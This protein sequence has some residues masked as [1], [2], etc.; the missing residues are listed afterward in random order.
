MRGLRTLHTRVRSHEENALAIARLLDRHDAVTRVHYPGLVTHPDHPLARAQ[1][2]GFGGI[3]S[4]QL[5]GGEQAIHAF[6]NGLKCFTLAESLGG[7]E[8][9]VCHP[10]TMT[11]AAMSGEA[12]A[13]AGIGPAL[14]RLSVGIEYMPDL[15]SDVARALERVLKTASVKPNMARSA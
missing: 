13:E 8:S 5:N 12:Q 9:L 2:S 4:F 7:V 3:I 1:Q 14:L 10:A 15:V 6:L 11:H